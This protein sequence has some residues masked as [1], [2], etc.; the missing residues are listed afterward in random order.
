[1]PRWGAGA[2]RFGVPA[3]IRRTSTLREPRRLIAEA[4]ARF[5]LTQRER[6]TLGALAQ[7]EGMTARDLVAILELVENEGL[8]PWLG[9][10]MDFGV[11]QSSGRTSGKRYFITPEFLRG[12]RLDQ[13]TTLTR[14]PPHRL[15]TLILEDL[16]R[17]PGSSSTDVNRR[18][19]A[20]ISAKTVKRALDAL[21][22]EGTIRFVGERRWRR[23]WL[24]EQTD[25]GHICL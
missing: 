13:K 5:Q 20:E 1:M 14:I 4:D 8:R 10:L 11:V 7:T 2:P 19:G 24:T 21:V 12:A 18:I 9:R 15:R 16:E 25:I 3:V 22:A 6:I 23:Y 17:Y